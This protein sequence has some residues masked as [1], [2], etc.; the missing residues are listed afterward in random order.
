MD[1]PGWSSAFGLPQCSQLQSQ[2]QSQSQLQSRL[3]TAVDKRPLH[4]PPR[5]ASNANAAAVAS[6]DS[7]EKKSSLQTQI[8]EIIALNPIVIISKTTC[9][10]S[11][12]AK[13]AL[14]GAGATNMPTVELDRLEPDVME[15]I[16]EHMMTLTG[17][18]TV[19]RVFVGHKFIGGGT[20]VA[21][22]AAR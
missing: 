14:K 20:D 12:Q 10:F 4:M 15:Q 6:R 2:S 5:A 18:R 17:A 3:L 1:G 8:E 11:D 16:Q 19:P 22:L 9:P 21:N 7:L 13:D